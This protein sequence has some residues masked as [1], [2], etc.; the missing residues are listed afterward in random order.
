MKGLKPI[1]HGLDVTGENGVIPEKA[2]IQIF[3]I[4]V[5]S[6]NLDARFRGHDGLGHGLFIG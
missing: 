2:G 5:F 6:N 3:V 4:V 1:L